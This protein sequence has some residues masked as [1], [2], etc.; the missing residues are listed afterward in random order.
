MTDKEREEIGKRLCEG[1]R[2]TAAALWNQAIMNMGAE[3]WPEDEA[4]DAW[5][6]ACVEKAWRIHWGECDG[7]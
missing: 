5:M 2:W 4:A 1:A 6:A 3:P 7:E